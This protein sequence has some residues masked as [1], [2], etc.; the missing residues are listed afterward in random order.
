MIIFFK[1]LDNTYEKEGLGLSSTLPTAPATH[2]T[3]APTQV[4]DPTAEPAAERFS[5]S[6]GHLTFLVLP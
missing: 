4:Q 2:Q 5:E 1:Y 6:L 3:H